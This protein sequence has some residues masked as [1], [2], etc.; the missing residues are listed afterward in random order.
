DG[1]HVLQALDGPKDEGAM[2][3]GAGIGH[4]KVIAPRLGFEARVADAV[5][6][7]RLF[8]LELPACRLGV[9][10]DVM[11]DAVDELA[12]GAQP[13]S[14]AVIFATCSPWK[15]ARSSSVWLGWRDPSAPAMVPAP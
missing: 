10:P 2:G 1:D 7:V 14:L 13:R 6:E 3:P 8:A 15:R 11:P 4:V 12:H 9:V 5:A